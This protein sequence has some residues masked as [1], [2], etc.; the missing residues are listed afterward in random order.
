MIANND[1]LSSDAGNRIISSL[2]HKNPLFRYTHAVNVQYVANL[3]TLSFNLPHF[4]SS[5]LHNISLAVFLSMFEVLVGAPG[6]KKVLHALHHP[7][8]NPIHTQSCVKAL[9]DFNGIAKAILKLKTKKA[10][11]PFSSHT[12]L[13]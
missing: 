12:F 11:F 2:Q 10:L 1:P 9:E 7:Q 6:V 8:F 13:V 3:S 5:E 4:E